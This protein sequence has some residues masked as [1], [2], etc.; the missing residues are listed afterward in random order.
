MNTK[1]RNILRGSIILNIVLIIIVAWGF[2]TIHFAKEQLYIT[3]VQNNLIEL[4]GLIGHQQKNNWSEPNLVTTEVGDILEGIYL[5]L[6]NGKYTK[7]ISKADKRT[8][9]KLSSSLRQY[10]HDTLYKFSELTQEDKN[11]FEELRM[12][13]REVGLGLNITVGD[14]LGSLMNEANALVELIG[15]PLNQ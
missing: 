10:P 13:L 9:E 8:L 3:A 7:S 6:S 2:I 5:S 11:N 14:D 12:N 15:Y 4:E 1:Q